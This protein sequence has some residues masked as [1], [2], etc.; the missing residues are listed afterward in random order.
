MKRNADSAQLIDRPLH[1]GRESDRDESGPLPTGDEPE[2]RF[3][4]RFGIRWIER[5]RSND[6]REFERI[7]VERFDM[8]AK[9]RIHC[10]CQSV[11]EHRVFVAWFLFDSTQAIG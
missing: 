11:E 10:A 3:P 8:S 9:P 6:P 7:A 2:R 4:K 5:I 1:R